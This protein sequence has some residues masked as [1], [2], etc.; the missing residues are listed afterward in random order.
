LRSIFARFWPLTKPLRTRLY[1]SLVLV[2]VA[3]VLSTAEIGMFKIL[4]DRVVVPHDFHLFPL[5]AVTYLGLTLLEGA[6]S[7]T[8]Q[9]LSTW[10]G[11]RFVLILRTRLFSHLHRLSS[12]FFDSR[13]LGDLL[14]RLTGDTG[15]IETLVLSGVAAGVTYVTKLVLFTGAMF[16]L[17]W[18]LAG[19][20]LLAAPGFLGAARVFSRRIKTASREKR[21]R[22]AAITSVAEES[23][24]NAALIRA[25]DR[26]EAEDTRFH[27]QNQAVFTAQMSATRLQAVFGPLTD[28]IET[29]G[30]LLVIGLAIWEL[31]A[32]RISIGGLLVFMAYMAQLY[33]PIQGLSSLMNSLYAASAGAERVIELLDETPTI[34][35]PTTPTSLDRAA[36]ALRVHQV[37]FTYPGTDAPA[38]SGIDLDIA[39]GQTVA[40]V[41]ASGAGKSTLAKLL[42]RFY[43]P[44]VGSIT[45]D[46]IDLR[47]LPLPDLYRN[48]ATVLQETL[49][50]D[51]TVRENILWGQPEATDHEIIAAATAADAHEFITALPLGYDTP[52]GQRGRKL[53][54][55]QRQ[56]VAIARALIR[57]APV[58]LL[59]EPTTGLD[60]DSTRRVL[61]PLRRLIAGRTMII[62][63][64]NLLTVTDADA[65]LYLEHGRIAGTGTHTQLL[66]DCP[67]YRRLYHL[68]QHPDGPHLAHPPLKLA[69]VHPRPPT[70]AIHPPSIPPPTPAATPT[71]TATSSA[72]E[73]S[74]LEF[75]GVGYR[76]PDHRLETVAEV[77]FRLPRGG[78]LAIMGPSGAG[79]STLLRLLTR[80]LRPGRGTIRFDGN[81]LSHLDPHWLRQR[82][83]LVPTD[84]DPD[85]DTDGDIGTGTPR[86]PDDDTDNTRDSGSQVGAGPR[87]D[88]S[89]DAS[90]ETVQFD[91]LDHLGNPLRFATAKTSTAPAQD[92]PAQNAPHG[93][94]RDLA[95]SRLRR[96]RAAISRAL[97]T[98]PDVLLLDNPTV[99]LDPYDRGELLGTLCL[100][101][102]DH[103]MLIVTHDPVVGALAEQVIHL[104]TRTHTATD[105]STGT[106]TDVGS[107]HRLTPPKQTVLE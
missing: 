38:L 26:A 24:G 98:R 34:T 43:D 90:Q 5:I 11:E 68:H 61:T 101:A 87:A 40:I 82:I 35:N 75:V 97:R 60:A 3:P 55:G 88:I 56:R 64:H 39:A 91:R 30:V 93:A 46:G 47:Q 37:G 15:A 92:T 89:P 77:S 107:R 96:R 102:V 51:G 80:Q 1:I 104:H 49:V 13:P 22:V 33:S 54:G 50:F 59:D 32:G 95:S 65:I 69:P 52:I 85:F 36:G 103:T 73:Q 21:R 84:T 7:F 105:T 106:A 100:L 63:S 53:S 62:I 45:L 83:A 58:L 2:V 94:E 9:Y 19:A 66:H 14:S 20:S 72:V 29:I 44:D 28:V 86:H 4:I 74:Y 57:D 25:Y 78:C 27:T 17:D 48:I 81:D 99:G 31:A 6:V 8:D 12:G 41:G 16:Y 79:K 10:V 70:T 67:G 42:L 76:Y 18:R 23:F 71:T